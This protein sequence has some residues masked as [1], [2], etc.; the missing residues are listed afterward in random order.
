MSS[1]RV[2]A[3]VPARGGSKGLPGKNLRSVGGVSLLGR[4]VAA[5]VGASSV[6]S[7]WVSTDDAAIAAEARRWGAGVIERP[8][9][10]AQDTSSSEA[11]LLHGLDVLEQ[12]EGLPETLV[13]LQCTSPFTTAA[14]IDGAVAHLRK[15]GAASLF[16]ATASHAF[17]WRQ[18]EDG[19]YGANHDAT[20]RLRRQDREPEW[21]ENGAVYVM[22]A[23][24]F[25]ASKHRFFGKIVPYE[26]PS[27]TA[28]EVDDLADLQLARALSATVG[29]QPSLPR[30]PRALVMDF[31]GVFTDNTVFVREDGVESVQCH[32]GDGMGLSRLRAA[33]LP[34]LILSKERNPVVTARATKLNIP[35]LQ[36]RDHKL[37]DLTGWAEQQGLALDDIFYVGND[38]NDVE[39]LRACGMGIVVADAHTD[40]L[41]VADLVLQ[42][43][44]GQ[45]ALRE[46]AD[47]I[48]PL[49]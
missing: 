10:L 28:L 30:A 14:D 36:G 5:A 2:V 11:A 33:G 27:V 29:E 13:F 6:D 15:T 4:T 26:T 39:C 37:Q 49:L 48:L 35:V 21:R 18:N 45:G 1:S 42:R 46:L 34:L 41:A 32:R 25:R 12:G 23:A 3:I 7:V 44:G 9:E 19:A 47:L 38:T 31:D 40:A 16:S 22:D 17:I 43:S 24:G 20:R 8:A